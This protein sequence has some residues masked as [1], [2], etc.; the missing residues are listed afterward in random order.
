M[1]QVVSRLLKTNPGGGACRTKPLARPQAPGP[2]NLE[3]DEEVQWDPPRSIIRSKER[4]V[5][6]GYLSPQNPQEGTAR[7]DRALPHMG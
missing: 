3:I 5:S 6:M 7:G 4:N 2:R 1:L